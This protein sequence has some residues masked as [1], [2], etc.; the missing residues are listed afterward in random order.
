[1]IDLD[2]IF[3]M[4]SLEFLKSLYFGSNYK[5]NTTKFELFLKMVFFLNEEISKFRHIFLVIQKSSIQEWNKSNFPSKCSF[6]SD[7]DKNKQSLAP[8]E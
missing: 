1:M 5:K 3:F 4:Q 6:K 2:E 8:C 7:E